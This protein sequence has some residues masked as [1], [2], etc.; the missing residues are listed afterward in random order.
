[1]SPSGLFFC[2]KIQYLR[3]PPWF[4]SF[5]NSPE[6]TVA[7]CRTYAKKCIFRKGLHPLSDV[8]IRSPY[9]SIQARYFWLKIIDFSCVIRKKAV[10]LRRNLEDYVFEHTKI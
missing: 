7:S 3:T 1:M 10:P 8:P 9:A 6:S 2:G 5:A 4:S